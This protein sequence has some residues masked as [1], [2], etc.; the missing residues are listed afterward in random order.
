M[1]PPFTSWQDMDSSERETLRE[2]LGGLITMRPDL[3]YAF[4]WKAESCLGSNGLLGSVIPASLLD[5]ASATRLRKK[6]AETMSPILIARLGNPLMFQGAMIDPA[7]YVAKKGAPVDQPM[8][9]FWADHRSSSSSRGLRQLRKGRLVSPSIY[10]V[11]ENGF[12]I[13]ENPSLGR[14]ENSWAP[15]PYTSWILLN[16]L[17]HLP[18]VRELFNVRQGVLSG[19]NKAFILKKPEWLDLPA[20]ERVFFRPVVINDSIQRGCLSDIVYIFYPYGS[21]RIETES[22]LGQSVNSYYE[23][24]LIPSK[25]RLKSRANIDQEKWWELTRHRDWQVDQKT[26]LMSTYFGDSGSFAWDDSGNYVICQG[27]A[28]LP[29]NRKGLSDGLSLAYLAILNSQLFSELLSATSNNVGGGQ[30]NLSARFVNIIA[31]PDLT[32]S[33]I[34]SS[35]AVATLCEIGEQIHSG[36]MDMVDKELYDEAVRVLYKVNVE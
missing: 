8:I 5:A 25:G 18:R 2:I 3:S 4:F 36:K 19:Y 9:A 34:R 31:I 30:W 11:R 27:Y 21:L 17:N 28:W 6:L 7:L 12:S 35:S 22:E 1:N 13:Y 29:K 24:Y 16:S 26:R 33:D 10:P 15:R 23:N 14:N 32:D 20:D